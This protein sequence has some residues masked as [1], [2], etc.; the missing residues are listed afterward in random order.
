[1][2]RPDI[3]KVSC[4]DWLTGWLGMSNLNNASNASNVNDVGSM[5][6]LNKATL[7]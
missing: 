3:L 4:I 6:R 2:G 7:Q 1:M 5:S